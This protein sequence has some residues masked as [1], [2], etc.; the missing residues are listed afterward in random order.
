M[1]VLVCGGRKYCNFWLIWRTL[2]DLHGRKTITK[3]VHGKGG[4]T[5]MSADAWAKAR[6]VEVQ[7]YPAN[8]ADI[9][10]PDAVIRTRKDG[11][12]YDAK[13]GVNRNQEMLD[14]EKV[15]LVVAFP[16]GTGTLDMMN[17][18]RKAGIQVMEVTEEI[19]DGWPQSLFGAEG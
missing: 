6:K 9:S 11:S 16:G 12:K 7:P 17:R 4:N 13:Q 8:W 19:D 1:V 10:R 14:K 2:D 18:A 15:E 5:D 3:M